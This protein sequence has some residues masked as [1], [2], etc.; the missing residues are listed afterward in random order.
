MVRESIGEVEKNHLGEKRYGGL[1]ET[2]V[3]C[4]QGRTC[5]P[6]K[7]RKKMGELMEQVGLGVGDT[8]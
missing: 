2:F 5:L 6:G 4:E 3:W 8:V 7:K 1:E